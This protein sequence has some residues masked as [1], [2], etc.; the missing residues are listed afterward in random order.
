MDPEVYRQMVRLFHQA[1]VTVGT[2][3]IGDRAIDWV[4]DTY[5]LV[6]K[7]TPTPGLRHT[8]IHAYL[9]TPHAITTMATLQKQ[10]DTGYPELQPGFLWW[11]G[12]TISASLGI[13]ELFDFR[14]VFAVSLSFKRKRPRHAGGAQG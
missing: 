10:Y 8:I 4:V 9:P 7:E 2:H 5:A 14:T 1:G 12:K 11:I 3:A 6:L 13:E